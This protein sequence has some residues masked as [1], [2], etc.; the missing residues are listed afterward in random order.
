MREFD[1]RAKKSAT[2]GVWKSAPPITRTDAATLHPW[3]RA[4]VPSDPGPV[5]EPARMSDQ[6]PHL[7]T[8]KQWLAEAGRSAATRDSVV[9]FEHAF[10]A[11][12]DRARPT[13]SEVT[14][15]AVAD[16]ALQ[17]G[18]E[19][20][21]LLAVVRIAENG[22]SLDALRR[23]ARSDAGEVREAL[24]LLLVEFL[25]ILGALSGGILTPALHAALVQTDCSQ[26]PDPESEEGRGEQPRNGKGDAR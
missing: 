3:S 1:P 5:L 14:L 26:A 10:Q 9:L 16:R 23:D 11:V 21:P 22:F 19:K 20:F 17:H 12:W 2:A 6:P 7:E 25:T 18:R 24:C 4:A 13:L 15:G 8:V